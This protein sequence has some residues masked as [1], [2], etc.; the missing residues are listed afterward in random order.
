MIN[1]IKMD[2][3]ALFVTPLCILAQIREV[4]LCKKSIDL[5][6]DIVSIAQTGW[7]RLRSGKQVFIFPGRM[8]R[9]FGRER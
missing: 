4:D 9:K 3:C 6:N 2:I 5:E 1:C 7:K 8:G